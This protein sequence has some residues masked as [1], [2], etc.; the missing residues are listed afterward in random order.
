MGL[1][2]DIKGVY[3]ADRFAVDAC[4]DDLATKSYVLC[5]YAYNEI[6][7]ELCPYPI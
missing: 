4:F 2:N 6:N 7:N 3:S 1:T 5:V